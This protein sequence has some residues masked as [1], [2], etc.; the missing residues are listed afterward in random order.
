MGE[1]S[2][3]NRRDALKII[4]G[5]AV[6]AMLPNVSVA[7]ANARKP[8]IIL[9]QCDQFRA[10]VCAREGFPLDTTPFIDSLARS[11][12]WFNRAYAASPSCV[13]SRNSF[14]TGRWPTATGIKSNANTNDSTNFKVGLDD[15]IKSQG[16]KMAAIGKMFHSYLRLR[17]QEFDC[18]KPY[19]H[20]G[21]PGATNPEVKKF[22]A[23]LE[24]TEFYASFEP[25][26]FPFEMQQPYR[27]VTDA[28]NWID[29][30]NGADPFFLYLSI[31]EPHNPYQVSEP[32]YSM[33]P[34]GQLPPVKA[35]PETIREKGQKYV[36]L[37]DLMGRAYPNLD[38]HI[39]RIRSL[40]F[41]MMRLIDDQ[42]K[43]LVDFLQRKGV[44]ENTLI[45]FT[46]DHG[47]YAGEYGLIKKGAGV[48]ECLTRIPM[49]WHGTGIVPGAA[50][51]PAHV[52]NTDV[53]PTICEMLGVPLPEGVQG[54]SLWPL[55]SGQAYPEKEFAS[56]L[57]MQGMGGLDYTSLNEL[58]P[59]REGA[60]QRDHPRY[61]DEVNSW[62]QS[63]V[64]RMLRKGDWKL[65]FDMLGRGELYH[66]SEDPAELKNLFGTPA[67]QSKQLEL[68]QDILSWELRTQDPLP[69]PDSG[70]RKYIMKIPPHNYL[71]N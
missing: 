51:H 7:A 9:I 27:M 62:T 30:L 42:V 52:S 64:L 47:D 29:S 49:I 8:N 46:A 34:P 1:L 5:V 11:G 57:V 2:V 48:P 37:K 22:N 66:L 17:S 23:F 50:A 40:Y 43:R 4:G 13:P 65:V 33:F 41:G 68:L 59:Y 56:M 10:D 15:V 18:F 38:E 58:S 53:F 3:I 28:Q 55:L 45:V 70:P 20:L 24:S 16:Y 69:L 63:G 44:Y 6:G 12:T 54:R 39:P 31:N 19:G 32:Y 61:F 35:G 36:Q 60:L 26:P 71:V 14:W 67:H 21:E 25:A